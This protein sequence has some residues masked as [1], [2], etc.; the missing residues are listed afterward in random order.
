MKFLDVDLIGKDRL[1]HAEL[2]V[3][4]SNITFNMYNERNGQISTF[5]QI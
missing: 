5:I 1:D 2:F 3:S 4:N